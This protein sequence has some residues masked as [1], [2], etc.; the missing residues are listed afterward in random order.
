MKASLGFLLPLS[1][2]VAGVLPSRAQ[3]GLD[4]V[5]EQMVAAGREFRHVEADI[6]RTKVVVFV[7]DRSMDSGRFYFQ[8][9]GE[10][11][12]IR[13][14][15]TEPAEQ[16][17]LVA[18]GKAQL[19]RARINLVEEYDLGER[20]DMAE[21]L[22]LGF[23]TSNETLADDYDIALSG[24]ETVDGVLTSVLDLEPKSQ[25]VAGMF[26]AIRLWIDQERWIPV[27]TRLNEA[28]GDYQIVKYSDI[29]LN[30]RLGNN[31]FEL[32]LPRDV[33]R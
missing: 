32:N 28:G 8:G 24:E 13:L 2:L 29:V 1:L 21:F 6:E 18:N 25:R 30:G 23:G 4:T 5:L 26:P 9:G 3:T 17:L 15:I 27:Q 7:N 20:R 19:Y 10:D 33:N 14:T 16:D 11:S 31:T 22:A 12:R